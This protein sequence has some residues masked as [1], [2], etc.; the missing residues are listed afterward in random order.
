MFAV[1]VTPQEDA[2]A[3]IGEEN[4]RAPV[5]YVSDSRQRL[6]SENEDVFIC[7]GGDELPP[8]RK[9]VEEACASRIDIESA[10]FFATELFLNNAG[11][12]GTR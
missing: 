4:Y 3:S 11:D 12:R 2:P 10:G 5:V 7:A 9:G 8:H 1:I 6:S